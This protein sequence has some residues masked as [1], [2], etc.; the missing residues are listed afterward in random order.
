MFEQIAGEDVSF[1]WLLANKQTIQKYQVRNVIRIMADTMYINTI[2][3][4][5]IIIPND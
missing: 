3:Q 2:N 4:R 1:A 5:Y